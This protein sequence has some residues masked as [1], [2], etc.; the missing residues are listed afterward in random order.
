MEERNEGRLEE[1][2]ADAQ[3]ISTGCLLF[4]P[5]RFV[6]ISFSSLAKALINIRRR[7][8]SDMKN[9]GS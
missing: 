4:P 9:G 6:S 2:K 8:K 5:T 3:I 7:K 1:K